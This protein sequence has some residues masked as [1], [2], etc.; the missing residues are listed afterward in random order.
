MLNAQDVVDG[1]VNA[2]GMST[3][4]PES[5]AVAYS[6][7][8]WTRARVAI[9]NVVAPASQPEPA[10]HLRSVTSESDFCEV[11]RGVGDLSIITPRCLG[12]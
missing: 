8:A 11:T 9:R 2:A 12:S 7:V 5:C 6:A 10:C 3:A 4:T 1:K